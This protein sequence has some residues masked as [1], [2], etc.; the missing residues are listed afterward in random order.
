MSKQHKSQLSSAKDINWAQY[1]LNTNQHNVSPV[2]DTNEGNSLM[3]GGVLHQNELFRED[4]VK[5]LKHLLRHNIKLL[6]KGYSEQAVVEIEF[7]HISACIIRHLG[8]SIHDMF[9][10]LVWRDCV[11]ENGMGCGEL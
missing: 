11:S 5:C 3:S 1:G 4:Q 10:S 8:W 2:L 6:S 7:L 9:N